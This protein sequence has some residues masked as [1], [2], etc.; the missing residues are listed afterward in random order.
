[1]GTITDVVWEIITDNDELHSELTSIMQQTYA[2]P[3]PIS[4]QGQD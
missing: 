4:S 3:R 2:L 1:M